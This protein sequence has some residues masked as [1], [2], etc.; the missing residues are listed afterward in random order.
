MAIGATIAGVMAVAAIVI[1]LLPLQSAPI[2][3]IR[4]TES[5]KGS[6]SCFSG[7][8][9]KIV[10]GD[11]LDV[12]NTRIRLALV[13][14]PEIDEDWYGEAKSLTSE[15]CPVGSKAVVDEDDGQTGGSYGRM[16]AKV[17]CAGKVLNEE[18]LKADMAEIF[19]NFCATSEFRNEDWAREYGC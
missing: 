9:T 13:N 12:E 19:T 1:I 7:T 17:S 8:V 15:L 11:T 6:A 3:N 10:D 16:I 2:T 5:C 14:T 18:L 4:S